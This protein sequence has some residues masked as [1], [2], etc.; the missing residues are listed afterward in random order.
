MLTKRENLQEVL[1]GGN[2]DRYVN[3]FEYMYMVWFFDP[4]ATE[5]GGPMLGEGTTWKTDW[6]VTYSWP[7]G[8][9]GGMPVHNPAELIVLKDIL[10]WENIL[11]PNAPKTTYSDAAFTALSEMAAGCDRSEQYLTMMVFPGLFEFTHL[12]MGMEGAL[13]AI[14]SEPDT[15]REM[16]FWY[17]DWEIANSKNIVDCIHP[18]C[19]LHHDD[20][21]SQISTFMSPDSFR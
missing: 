21:G 8:Y 12:V 19:L 11:K 2:P 10:Q 15:L 6:G 16:L 20:W 13:L 14:A 7:A 3:Q 1:K 17:V 18:D 9:P 4:E 5:Q